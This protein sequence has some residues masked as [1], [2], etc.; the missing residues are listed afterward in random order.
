MVLGDIGSIE[1]LNGGRRRPHSRPTAVSSSNGRLIAKLALDSKFSMKFHE[2]M[3]IQ[4]EKRRK[5][6]EKTSRIEFPS[7]V[8][9]SL[10]LSELTAQFFKPDGY[11]SEPIM[12]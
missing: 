11:T 6:L 9:P 7:F 1:I 5:P 8:L 12:K 10:L 2:F 3:S 4:C